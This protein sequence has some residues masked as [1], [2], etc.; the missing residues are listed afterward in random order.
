MHYFKRH[1]R[2]LKNASIVILGICLGSNFQHGLVPLAF[3]GSVLGLQSVKLL[4]TFC[5]TCFIAS[6]LGFKVLDGIQELNGPSLISAAIEV[7]IQLQQEIFIGLS[8]FT[9]VMGK[10]NDFGVFFID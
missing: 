5:D 7:Y 9:Q 4:I 8:L 2:I 3:Y 1:S 10:C 6:L